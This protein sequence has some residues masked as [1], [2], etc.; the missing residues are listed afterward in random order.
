MQRL[1]QCKDDCHVPVLLPTDGRVL[2]DLYGVV[3]GWGLCG[4]WWAE[5]GRWRVGGG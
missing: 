3:L 4:W 5:G 1:L 2:N